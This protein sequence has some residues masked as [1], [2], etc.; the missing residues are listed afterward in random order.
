[1]ILLSEILEKNLYEDTIIFAHRDKDG[2]DI[3]FNISTLMTDP[4]VK[5]HSIR[6]IEINPHDAIEVLRKSGIEKKHLLRLW[7]K[8]NDDPILMADMNDGYI[9]IDG[10]H[11]YVLRALKEKKWIY[12][13]VISSKIWK[14]HL[15]E[16]ISKK[17]MDHL[18]DQNSSYFIEEL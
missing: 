16:G 5:R 2:T 8:E 13:K 15:I 3:V 18:I 1:M 4:R 12:A 6:K 7:N 9:I 11:R 10:N 17:Q 14:E